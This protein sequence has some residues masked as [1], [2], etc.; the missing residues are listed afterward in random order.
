MVITEARPPVQAVFLLRLVAAM[1]LFGQA[2][3]V[4]FVVLAGWLLLVVSVYVFNGI[5]DLA[6]DSANGSRRPIASGR[7]TPDAALH[8]CLGASACGLAL[9]WLAGPNVF[10]LGVVMLV[11]GWAYSAGPAW[12]NTPVGFGVVVGLGAALTYLV[13]WFAGGSADVRRLVAMLAIAAWVGLCCASK[14]F[15]DVAGDRLAGRRTWPVSLGPHR[16]ALLLG[17]IA[18]TT[19]SVVLAGSIMSGVPLAPAAI[20]LTGSVVLAAISIAA[21]ADRSRE[22]RRR[23]YQAFMATQ[24]AANLALIILGLMPS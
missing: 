18:I 8:F 19:G 24:Y 7:L 4:D 12:K 10:G 9:C 14:D 13:G 20:L 3:A 16:A 17:A 21:A 6:A 5:T 23:P 1:S 15:S 11:L 2:R 22:V